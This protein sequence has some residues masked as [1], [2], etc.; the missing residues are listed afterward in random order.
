MRKKIYQIVHVYNSSAVSVIYKYCMTA[1]IL[2]SLIPLVFKEEYPVFW[3]TDVCC[4]AIFFIDFVLRWVTAD[5]KLK[6]D[7]WK[8]FVRFPV[9]TISIVDI[10]SMIALLSSVLR[11]QIGSL[12]Q[13]LT[14]FRIIRILRY[15]KSVNT[16]MDILRKSK[17]PLTAVGSLAVGY[18]L[19]SAVLLF[20]VEPD[21]FDTFFDAVY[22]STVSL[23][24]VGYGDLYPVT[25]LGRAVAMV[26]SFFGIAVV[27]LPAGI[28]TAE[29]MKTVK[30]DGVL[31]CTPFV[32]QV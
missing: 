16:I 19:I 5:Y 6:I 24:T 17:K 29:Y 9:R 23:T 27:A 31:N 14:V 8:A 21:S 30:K 12:T 20:N 11:W 15:S 22:W 1:V 10:I 25:T 18:I 3:I 2:L 4:L 28:V 7:G 13:V 26:S 32:R